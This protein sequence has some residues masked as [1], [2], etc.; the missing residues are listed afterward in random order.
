MGVVAACKQEPTSS[1]FTWLMIRRKMVEAVQDL[2]KGETN[3]E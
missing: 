3:K 2:A 1:I